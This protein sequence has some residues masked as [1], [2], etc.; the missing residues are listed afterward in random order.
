MTLYAP[1]HFVGTDPERARALIDAHPFASLITAADAAEPVVSH[2]PLLRDGDTG[3]IGHMARANPHW[4][5]FATGRTLAV[6]HGPHAYVSPRW[7]AQ[8]QTTVPTWNYA[9][10]H[11][12]GE[13]QLLDDAASRSALQ[14]LTQ[15]FDPAFVSDALVVERLQRGIVAFRMAVTRIDAKFKMS[16]NKGAADRMGVIAG[17]RESG[18]EGDIAVADWMQAHE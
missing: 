2:L 9:V 18:A 11:V 13:M 14:V 4:T 7:Y 3:L 10:V 5:R 6:F 17:L 1:P 16:Q 15:R 12:Q 8:P